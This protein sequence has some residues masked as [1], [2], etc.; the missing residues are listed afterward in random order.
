MRRGDQVG[1]QRSQASV[2]LVNL[3]GGGGKSAVDIGDSG[4]DLP[5]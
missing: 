5:A 4:I 3:G 2:C 1:A